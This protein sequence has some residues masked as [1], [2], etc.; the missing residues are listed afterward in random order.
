ML[1]TWGNYHEAA[2][3]VLVDM[4]WSVVEFPAARNSQIRWKQAVKEELQWESG[5]TCSCG[6]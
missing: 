6:T 4:T 2:V 3:V 5:R 1:Q